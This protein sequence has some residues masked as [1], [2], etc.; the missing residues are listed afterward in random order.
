VF[1]S[2]K[3]DVLHICE[4]FAIKIRMISIYDL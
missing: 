2:I 1:V 4:L 3:F